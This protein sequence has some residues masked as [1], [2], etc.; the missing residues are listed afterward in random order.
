MYLEV[1][2]TEPISETSS[3]NKELD[4]LKE[5]YP[6]LISTITD[7]DNLLAYCVQEKIIGFS[8]EGQIRHIQGQ[9][10]KVKSL[11]EH[12]SGP[13]EGGNDRGFYKFLDIMKSEGKQATK[14]LALSME[15]SLSNYS[16][17]TV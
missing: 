3:F 1:D 16:T 17:L 9:P 12:I 7:I 5:Y 6:K 11:L 10:D 2:V 13:L 4:V 14:D 8:E 15:Q